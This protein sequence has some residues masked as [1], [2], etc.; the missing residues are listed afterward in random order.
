MSALGIA[1]MRYAS[2]DDYNEL[3]RNAISG[4]LGLELQMMGVPEKS[5]ASRRRFSTYRLNESSAS[6]GWF[7]KSAKPGGEVLICVM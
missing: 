3:H 2:D 5:N 1:P 7:A 4:A 6:C